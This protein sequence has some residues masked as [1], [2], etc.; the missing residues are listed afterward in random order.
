MSLHC[1]HLL[2][3]DLAAL[4]ILTMVEDSAA[5]SMNLEGFELM[6]EGL[7]TPETPES[8]LSNSGSEV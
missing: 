4:A 2:G 6:P 8:C 1:K 7:V 5:K 3:S